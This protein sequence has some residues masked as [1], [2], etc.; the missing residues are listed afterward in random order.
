M[1]MAVVL[2]MLK[3]EKEMITIHLTDFCKEAKKLLVIHQLLIEW[4]NQWIR[5]VALQ[6]ETQ[7]Y[8][9][10]DT[11]LMNRELC[12]FPLVN[13]KMWSV[14]VDTG[15]IVTNQNILWNQDLQTMPTKNQKVLR[16]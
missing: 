14:M 4:M 15:E 13:F 10:R 12:Y 8:Q 7:L 1:N 9:E 16:T 11:I 5:R 2:M 3:M 6:K